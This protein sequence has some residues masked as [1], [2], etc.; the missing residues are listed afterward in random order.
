MLFTSIFFFPHCWLSDE[1]CAQFCPCLEQKGLK[2]NTEEK[3]ENNGDQ[4]F[5]HFPN[6]SFYDLNSIFDSYSIRGPQ[7]LSALTILKMRFL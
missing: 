6:C 2:K 5:L 1:K 3:E 4:P 7:L